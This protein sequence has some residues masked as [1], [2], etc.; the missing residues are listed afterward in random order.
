[1]KNTLLYKCTTLFATPSNKKKTT[2]FNGLLT[3][4]L[5]VMGMGVSWG[6]QLGT[7]SGSSTTATGVVSNITFGTLA[8]GAGVG[9]TTA[10]GYYVSSNWDNTTRALARTNNEYHGFSVQS[11]SNFITTYTSFKYTGYRTSAGPTIIG[12]AYSTDGGSNWTDSPDLTLTTASTDYTTTWDFPDFSTTSSV[13]IRI[14]G[15]SASGT[16][17]LRTKDF[18]LNGSVTSTATPTIVLSSPSQIAAASVNQG[19]TSHILSNFEAAVTVAN[20]T[21]NSIAVVTG[22]SY[23]TSSHVS[24]YKLM[25]NASSNTFGSA[26]QIGTTQSSVAPGNT[27]TFSSLNT[28]ITSGNTGYFWVIADISSLATDSQTIN[29]AASPS[30]TF[31]S[32][33]PTGSISAGGAQTFLAVTPNIAISSNHPIATNINQNTT[34][35]VFGSIALA[36]TTANAALNSIAITTS[37]TYQTSDL[38]ASSF[39]LYYTTSN[40]FATTTQLGSAQ[41]IV[42]SGNTLTFSGLS[43]IINS[44]VTGYL[45]FTADIAYNAVNGRTLSATS[46]VFNNITFA[47]GTKTGTNPVATG[48]DQ[49]IT[50]VTPSIAIAQNGPTTSN[51]NQGTTNVILYGLSLAVTANTT[52]FN[53]L[54]V[55][56]GG[57]YQT[58]DLLAS[59]FKLYYT[60]ANSFSSTTQLSTSQ[61]IVSS[62][63]T[64]TFSGINQN[65]VTGTTGYLWVTVDISASSVATRTI[66]V[67]STAFSN[68]TFAAGNKTGTDPAIAGGVRTITA[69][70]SLT[71]VVFPQYFQGL[72]GTNSNRLPTAFF[73]TLNNLNANAT[74]KYFLGAVIS[75]DLSTASGAGNNIFVDAVGF[76]RA[77]GTSLST[78]GQFAT[79]TTNSSGSYSG[80]FAFEPTGNSRFAV[81]NDVFIRMT[82]N[83]GA[84]GTIATTYLTTTNTAKVINLVNSAGA[85]NGTGLRGMSFA[86]ARNFSVIYDNISASGRPISVS[87]IES[88]GSDNSTSNSYA[89]FYGTSVNASAGA[90]GVIIPNTNANGIKRIDFKSI[91]DNSLIYSVTDADGNW[92]GSVNTVN[93]TG[94][95]TALI[96]PQTFDDLIVNSNVTLSAATSVFGN[97]T[98]QNSATL[99]T[100]GL[101]SLKSNAS[102]TA[103]IGSLT[104]GTI[105]GNVTVE[106]YIPAKRAWRALT[107]PLKGSDKSIFSQW[108]NNG[109]VSS[110][111]GIEL[112]N[113]N[114]DAN[115]SS[116]NSGLA[117]GPNSSILQYVAGAWSGVSNTNS[118]HL[119]TTSGNNAFMVFPTGGFGSGNIASSTTAVATTLK[120]TGQL[121]TGDVNYSG[122]TN[123]SHTLIGNPYASPID[124]N[125]ILDAN[126]TLQKYFWVWD[127]NGANQGTY[128]LFDATA[129]T[130]AVTN[131]S[132]TNS[133]VIQSGQ[134]FF[135]KA[136]TGQTGSFTISEN[137]K[138]TATATNVFRNNTLPELLRVGLYKQV[139]N[140]WS[141]RDGAMTV[142]LSDADAN[143]ASNKMANGTEN[144]AFTKNGASFASNHHLPLVASD[145]LNV[146]VW[147]TTAGA[148]YKLKINTEEFSATN[149]DATLEDLYTNARTPLTLDGTAVEYPFTVTT[150]A[151]STGDRFRI[152]FQSSQLGNNIPK[153]NGFSIVPNPVTGDSFHV[154]L[155]SLATGT[156]FYSICN[157]IGQEVAKGTIQN[158]AQNT[159]YEI[160]MSNS[161]TGIYI[162][163]IKG[164]DNSVFTAKIIKK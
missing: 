24:N 49:T 132:Y 141:G 67:T 61:E 12:A 143:Q 8:R 58:T 90:Y 76:T 96:L 133:T 47:S 142:I 54:T 100:A 78:A 51:V 159:N 25:Y 83:D 72:S 146:K 26:I 152:V 127:P 135:V 91:T 2:R 153:S 27:V 39:R 33:T 37:G 145:V 97:I 129:N 9:S 44:G 89:S 10:T 14:Y 114:G 124:L 6:Q 71:E 113:P 130:Y 148:N 116:S 94:G 43:Q 65:I 22:G 119:F 101:L 34:N 107:S 151:L 45:W 105:S 21:L 86:A 5:M 84:V 112:W 150:E 131:L 70:P 53:N 42:A 63:N 93:P 161:A 102:G 17:N 128:N 32:G 110:G 1:M 138:S 68:I 158:A 62:G 52:D 15:W 41:A 81:G 115:P 134:S 88:D 36:V 155:G 13:I 117:I 38:L 64:I 28:A 40:T 125:S 73:F 164:S 46:T 79:F 30:L 3:L 59:S 18:V 162:M 77:T 48:N 120:A 7:Y 147:N 29:I 31:A 99:T 95:T 137:N 149:L 121:I 82:L 4:F 160:K 98:I 123:A 56:T 154:N 126:A 11:D 87:F 122:I 85:T 35:K 139:N 118:T 92:G 60:T 69:P 55:T 136:A 80:W 108:Q 144:I 106:R 20:A 74:Y 111:V 103:S 157:T 109:T 140:E 104:S 16:G 23:A 156:Y 66:Y 57:T 163:K 75:S 19:T 50:A